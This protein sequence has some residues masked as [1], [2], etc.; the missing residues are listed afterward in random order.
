MH[1]ELVKVDKEYCWADSFIT[2]QYIRNELKRFKRFISNIVPLIRNHMHPAQ[3][4]YV[5]SKI[6]VSDIVTKEINAKTFLKGKEWINVPKI[7]YKD[8]QH[9]QKAN[10][11]MNLESDIEVQKEK[12]FITNLKRNPMN[13]LLTSF[14]GWY[15]IRMKV[16]IMIRIKN[17][18]KTRIWKKGIFSILELKEAA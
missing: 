17:G 7:L 9:W 15:K 18:L 1:K 14:S 12:I 3:W 16:A 4:N 10:V 13:Q 11:N 5:P 8:E 6:N 2:L